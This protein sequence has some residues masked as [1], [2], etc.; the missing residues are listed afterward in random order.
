[1]TGASWETFTTHTDNRTTSSWPCGVTGLGVLAGTTGRRGQ[2]RE[3]DG[4]TWR[5]SPPARA[6][7]NTVRAIHAIVTGLG[8]APRMGQL[9]VRNGLPPW[10]QHSRPHMDWG[11]CHQHPLGRSARERMGRHAGRWDQPHYRRW[12]KLA[13]LLTDRENRFQHRRG[14]LGRRCREHLGLYQQRHKPHHRRWADLAD[15][16]PR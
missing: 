3:D 4:P 9:P 14:T 15:L 5:T 8:S 7:D 2:F 11:R 16:H 12:S 1:M 13:D 6:G 10:Q